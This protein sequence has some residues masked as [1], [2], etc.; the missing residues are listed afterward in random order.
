MFAHKG[1][2][3]MEK[4]R[5]ML[6]LVAVCVSLN[7]LLNLVFVPRYGYQAAAVTTLVSF[8][9]YPLLVY[10]ASRDALPWAVPWRTLATVT[11]ASVI[12][13]VVLAI[14]RGFLRVPA[15]V[16]LAAGAVA[17]P[18]V[19]ISILTLLREFK[20]YERAWLWRGR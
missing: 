13:G 10:R 19:Y 18:I 4:T 11:V 3:V 12:T 20:P 8:L 16:I 1:L 9:A 2:E 5:V 17:G 15:G 14:L 6:V 7:I